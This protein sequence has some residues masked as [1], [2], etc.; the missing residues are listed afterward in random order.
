M[1]GNGRKTVTLLLALGFILGALAVFAPAGAAAG[2]A[3]PNFS[4]TVTFTNSTGGQVSS[5]M[6]GEVV[7]ITA[8]ASIVSGGFNS[9]QFMLELDI[10]DQ[11]FGTDFGPVVLNTGGFQQNTW[12]WTVTKYGNFTVNM[13]AIN[14]TDTANQTVVSNQF[15]GLATD[16]SL[17]ALTV[18]PA[19]GYVGLTSFTFTAVVN[20]AGNLAGPANASLYLDN[21]SSALIG[22]AVASAIP[23]A[24]GGTPGTA[25]AVFAG[26]ITVSGLADGSN[27]TVTARLMD[28]ST[29]YSTSANVTLTNPAPDVMVNTLAANPSSVTITK[30]RTVNV[31]VTANITNNGQLDAIGATLSFYETDTTAAKFT[32][33]AFNLSV[34]ASTD[35]VWTWAVTDTVALGVHTIYVQVASETQ[36]MWTNL[37]VTII[38]VANVTIASLVPSAVTAFEGDNV[39]FTA[40]L[41]NNGTDDSVNQTI[42]WWDA[43]GA[44]P[45]QI[46]T[47][48]N[49]T[50]L[51]GQN[52]PFAFVWT[53]P[54]V[55]VDG[56]K[57]VKAT[58]GAAALSVNVMDRNKAPKIEIMAFTVQ[59]GRIGDN[60][61]MT[62]TVK[63]NGTGDAIGLVVDFYDGTTKTASYAAFNLSVQGSK[64]VTV[65]YIQAG[66]AD[67][68][69]TFSVQALGAQKNITQTVGHTLAPAAINIVSFTVKPTKKEGQA[70]DSTQDYKL[71]I[72]LKNTGEVMGVCLL[73]ITE[74]GK[75]VTVIPVPVILDGGASTT[76]NYTWKVKGDGDHTAVATLSGDAG[77]TKTMSVKATLKYSPGFEVLVL[78]AAIIV[79]VILVRR[80]K[81]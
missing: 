37:S 33:D 11:T 60:I 53:L 26:M 6:V 7:N 68:N 18:A 9:T 16:L 22:Y 70:K 72:T 58:I 28:I 48:V 44:T 10:D 62:A 36:D 25:N 27:H 43:T 65:Y 14:G 50:V 41:F 76:Q 73:N 80:R 8:N 46:G 31:V 38:G 61:T 35:I 66:I 51:K 81:N 15:T 39:T 3:A 30:G 54:Q 71:T 5:A 32:S 4:V 64:S 57:T 42:T 34:G 69:H 20:N 49:V 17:G 47:T 63:N 74:K 12:A 45:A 24:T 59:N 55:D 78:V 19:T 21:S 23:A 77:T 75:L 29:T 67:A 13:T 79:A 40:T 52:K 2:R 1:T 56:N